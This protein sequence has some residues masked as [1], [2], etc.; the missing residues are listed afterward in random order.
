MQY[1]DTVIHKCHIS[2]QTCLQDGFLAES[3]S[4]YLDEKKPKQV[5]VSENKEDLK[6]RSI[7]DYCTVKEKPQTIEDKICPSNYFW[8]L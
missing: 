2:T 8:L 4:L 7:E 3:H 6:D 5:T 1:F